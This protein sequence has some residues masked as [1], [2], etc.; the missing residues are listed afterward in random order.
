MRRLSD[1]GVVYLGVALSL[2]IATMIGCGGSGGGG[3]VISGVPNTTNGV[4][5][6]SASPTPAPASSGTVSCVTWLAGAGTS[7]NAEALQGFRMYPDTLTINAGDT[8]TWRFTTVE[9]HTITFPIAGHTPPP[10]TDPSAPV[11]A[12][13]ST[14]DGSTYTSSGFKFK[15]MTYSLT[16]TKPGTYTFWCII[17]QPE[18]VGTV[19]VQT[20]GSSYP[21]TQASYDAEAAAAKASDLSAAGASVALFPYTPGGTHLVAGIAP[22]LVGPPTNQ[23]V[24]R[25]LD[26]PTLG[27]TSV[28]VAVGTTVTWTN[29]TNNAPHTVT[30]P[31]AGQTPPPTLSPFAPPSGPSSYDGTTL[32]NSGP[33]FPSGT[34]SLTF[35]KAGTFTY[36]CLFHDDSGMIG[37]IKVH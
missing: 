19:V 10:P 2:S 7:C 22:G 1:H 37:T 30:F 9:P 6:T 29:E 36:Y 5:Q 21:K 28:D 25:F 11:P 23:S 33:L 26:G 32:V 34:F 3:T 13:G 18:M 8:I 31:V 27:D 24:F 12:G 14:Y 17:H 15:G 20:A 4:R 16:F 35:T